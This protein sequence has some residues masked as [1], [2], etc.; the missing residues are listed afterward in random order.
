LIDTCRGAQ[1][2]ALHSILSP[3]FFSYPSHPPNR[4]SL[5]PVPMTL[6]ELARELNLS[7]ATISRA[8]NR[9]DDVAPATRERVLAAVHRNGN[10]QPG[11]PRSLRAQQTR[12]IGVI[13]SD[14]RNYFFAAFVKSIEDRARANGYTILICNA[15]EDKEKEEAALRM[16]L[17]RKVAGIIN[18]STGGNL[19]LLELVRRSGAILVDF[20]R[21]SGLDRTDAVTINNQ[22]GARLAVE[23]LTSLG[24]TRIATIAGPQHLSNGRARLLGFREALAKHSIEL[25]ADYV[26]IGNFQSEL[27]YTCSR[28]LLDLKHPP[29]A[30]FTANMEMAAGLIALVRERDIKLPNELSIVTFDDGFWAQYIDP[31]LTVIAQPVEAMGRFT[32]NLMLRRLR[33]NRGVERKMFN[34]E[35]IVR[36]STRAH[37]ARAEWARE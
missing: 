24:H 2:K 10:Y 30:I 12:T 11:R 17:D 18:C 26:Q 36:G 29:T 3:P 28:R 37:S 1:C 32:I 7:I 6:I 34:P 15:G 16:L 22:K 20:D 4:P 21:E 31:P 25:P 5:S 8:L 35:L 13:I 14:I 9:P 27:G 33:G 23:H 19:E